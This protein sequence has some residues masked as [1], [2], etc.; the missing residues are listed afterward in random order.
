MTELAYDASTVLG[1]LFEVIE[2]TLSPYR[3]PAAQP[4]KRIA[5]RKPKAKTRKWAS[6]KAKAVSKKAHTIGKTRKRRP[7]KTK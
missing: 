6:P 5:K 4:S 3:K 1:G 7:T 2:Q